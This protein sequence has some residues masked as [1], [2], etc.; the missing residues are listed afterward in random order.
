M[1]LVAYSFDPQNIPPHKGELC[2]GSHE[3]VRRQQ[4]VNKAIWRSLGH[5]DYR[6]RLANVTAPVL[7][8]HGIADVTPVEASEDWRRAVRTRAC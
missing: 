2:G 3:A 4:V 7:V 5:F 6:P 1:I 8:I